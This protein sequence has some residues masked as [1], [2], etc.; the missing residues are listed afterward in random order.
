MRATGGPPAKRTSAPGRNPPAFLKNARYGTSPRL[1]NP[2]S[3]KTV[4]IKSPAATI[5]KDPTMASWRRVEAEF[6]G[7]STCLSQ[8]SQ[9]QA[10]KSC[11]SRFLS[12]LARK[13]W[14]V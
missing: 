4:A 14:G 12:R 1:K 8:G 3:E 5:T 13:D 11:S 2:V 9:V 10:L 6:I 7:L